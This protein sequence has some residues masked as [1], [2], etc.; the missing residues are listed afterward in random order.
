MEAYRAKVLKFT[1]GTVV[2][3]SM[4]GIFSMVLA[5]ETDLWHKKSTKRR[6]LNGKN[7]LQSDEKNGDFPWRTDVFGHRTHGAQWVVIPICS[8][9][10]P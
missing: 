4:L 9:F 6:H 8:K 10:S 7:M 5:M 3:D 1:T 2:A